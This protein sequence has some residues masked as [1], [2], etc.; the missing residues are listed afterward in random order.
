LTGQS[1]IVDN[2][3]R[4]RPPPHLDSNGEAPLLK[5][6]RADAEAY[7]LPGRVW[8]LY[9]GPENSPAQNLT[10]GVA[11][12]PPGS[13]PPGHI[14]ETQEE[15]IYII[16]GSGQLVTSQGTAELSPGTAVFIPVG[17]HHATVS[18]GDEPLE[19]VSVFSPP[20]VPGSY[21]SKSG[22]Q[23]G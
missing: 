20:V 4:I 6:T 19:L 14:H 18:A 11:V 9:V 7:E 1:Q 3:L 2:R 21:E 16:S 8:H 17:L 23:P 22:Q 15:V 12:F 5:I 10:V 13:A